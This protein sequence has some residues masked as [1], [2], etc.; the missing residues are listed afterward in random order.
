MRGRDLSRRFLSDVR[1]QLE[2][3]RRGGRDQRLQ[4]VDHAVRRA[5]QRFADDPETLLLTLLGLADMYDRAQADSAAR[6]SVLAAAEA[7]EALLASGWH[8]RLVS[9][10]SNVSRRLVDVGEGARAEA[11]VRRVAPAH[12]A[13]NATNVKL[14][15][16]LVEAV[17]E[18]GET[19]RALEASRV[20][21]GLVE[22]LRQPRRESVDALRLHSRILEEVGD[23]GAA[24]PLRRALEIIRSSSEQNHA[25][26]VL[27]ELGDLL[28]RL[29]RSAEAIEPLEQ[30]REVRLRLMGPDSLE[31]RETEESLRR[32]TQ[33]LEE[34]EDVPP[35]TGGADDGMP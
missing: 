7:L 34:E 28:V 24:E 10:V 35:F 16:S 21:V 22:Q 29:G 3:M 9:H 17:R 13:P 20:A 15:A 23:P 1:G 30:A 18:Q 27:Q 8:P 25:Y 19:L 33:R 5:S 31:V 26:V 14:Q 6:E 2:G 32:A 4:V 12:P 11:I